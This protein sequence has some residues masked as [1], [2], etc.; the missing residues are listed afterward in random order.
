M[1]AETL[2]ALFPVGTNGTRILF[3]GGQRRLLGQSVRA[4]ADP[5]TDV[6]PSLWHGLLTVPLPRPKVSLW[7]GLPTVPLPRPKVSSSSPAKN[8]AVAIF[9]RILFDFR[10]PS[11]LPFAG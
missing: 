5:K 9:A 4:A 6:V 1:L 3:K 10:G 2:A 11:R 7:H 8:I